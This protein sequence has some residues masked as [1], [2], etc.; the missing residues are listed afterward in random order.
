M[1]KSMKILSVVMVL[2]LALSAFIGCANNPPTATSPPAVTKTPGGTQ[3]PGAT[4]TLSGEIKFGVV[5]SL[6]G[7]AAANHT[8][9]KDGITLAAKEINDAGG[10][11]G[12]KVVLQ[13]E[14]EQ[15]TPDGCVLATSKLYAT[16][17][18]ALLGPNRTAHTTAIMD[19]IKNG[20]KPCIC[21]STG[22]ALT[23]NNTN[24]WLFFGRPSDLVT[25]ANAAT[26]MAETLKLK[27]IG[28]FTVND[29]YGTACKNVL[30]QTF[31]SLGVTYVEGGH[32][33]GD[34][35]F[36]GQIV[37]FKNAGC[38]GVTSW[39]HSA[40]VA[41]FARQ[42]MEL[43]LNVP[44]V[45]SVSITESNTTD[46]LDAESL[47]GIYSVCDAAP[48]AQDPVMK[49]V[50]EKA[51]ATFGYE[52]NVMYMACHSTLYTVCWAI[53]KAGSTDPKAIA[54]ALRTLD[55][56]QLNTAEGK[57]ICNDQQVLTAL[58][59]IVQ[60]DNNKKLHTIAQLG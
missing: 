4:A 30:K 34:K 18:V 43:G 20:G 37:A 44:Y 50:I 24:P 6:T 39:T 8:R 33:A 54:D 23:A 45:G 36:S 12:K 16:N 5:L 27:K 22:A 47:A 1:K 48:D 11:L 52:I 59:L 32:N 56:T 46:L 35:D 13:I 38:D 26:F 15:T 7:D 60:Y 53:G 9:A 41:I 31:D 40:E 14:D 57:M 42:R 17:M 10:V 58:C 28:M 29:D 49:A 51:K 19:Q 25:V 3:G 21:W 2:I 55:G